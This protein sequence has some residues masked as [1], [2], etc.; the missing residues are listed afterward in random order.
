MTAKRVHPASRTDTEYD[1]AQT[2]LAIACEAE[3]LS[4]TSTAHAHL[5]SRPL[6]SCPGEP[7]C[8]LQAQLRAH[9]RSLF[10]GEDVPG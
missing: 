10:P 6:R 5:P 7:D 4:Y 8:H 2:L 3:V 9:V 1:T